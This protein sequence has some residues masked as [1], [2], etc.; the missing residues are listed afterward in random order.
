MRPSFS[1]C[2]SCA[3]LS[4]SN[5]EW[6]GQAWR[7][8]SYGMHVRGTN[9]CIPCCGWALWV[10]VQPTHTEEVVQ[11][12]FSGMSDC[13]EQVIDQERPTFDTDSSSCVWMIKADKRREWN[14]KID[15]KQTYVDVLHAR[16]RAYK[17]LSCLLLCLCLCLRLCLCLCLSLC[18]F[19]GP[20]S[21]PCLS[22]T[23]LVI[24][25]V[26]HSECAA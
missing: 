2:E 23:V 19:L 14:R 16:N 4:W 12:K 22:F 6:F 13:D 25:S 5:D 24:P 21:C 20:H 3:F 18:H 11:N 1:I 26:L 8:L 7:E 17:Y 10:L 15:I 9:G